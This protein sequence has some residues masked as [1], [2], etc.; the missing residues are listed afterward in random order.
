MLALAAVALLAGLPVTA[1][2]PYEQVIQLQ[3]GW[4][5]IYLHVRVEQNEIED[6]FSPANCGV[7]SVPLLSVWTF[8]ERWGTVGSIPD[9][10]QGLFTTTGWFG[11]FP[12]DRPESVLNNLFAVAPN[13]PYLVKIGGTQPITCTIPGR[14]ELRYLDWVPNSFNLV[15]LRVDPANPPTFE[16]YFSPSKAHAGQPIF[17]LDPS[18]T[19]QPVLPFVETARE[20]E[21]YWIYSAG[22]SKYQGPLEVEL[23]S[24]A[25]IEFEQSLT[26]ESLTFHNL[27]D[28]DAAVTLRR[29]PSSAPLPLKYRGFNAETSQSSWPE[30][31]DGFSVPV[32]AEDE[33]LLEIAPD[34]SMFA[35][36]AEQVLE[37]TSEFGARVLVPIAARTVGSSTPGTLG[38]RTTSGLSGS[39]S[40]IDFAQA[41][42]SGGTQAIATA[43]SQPLTGLW[44]GTANVTKVSEILCEVVPQDCAC[45]SPGSCSVNGNPCAVDGECSLVE[46]TC[47]AGACTASGDACAT[48]SDCPGVSQVCVEALIDPGDA[49]DCDPECSQG[50]I[51]SCNAR[52]CASATATDGVQP[53]GGSFPLRLLVHVDRQGNA[54]LLKEVIQLFKEPTYGPDPA[55]PGYQTIIDPGS[56]VLITDED[57][58]PEFGGVAMR[59]GKPVGL[60]ASTAAYDFSETTPGW[61]PETHSLPMT[62]SFGDNNFGVAVTIAMNKN[63]PTNPFRH[64]FHPDHNN[65]DNQFLPMDNVCSETEYACASDDDCNVPITLSPPNDGMC[66]PGG[67]PCMVGTNE[68]FCVAPD[69]MACENS[70]AD[71]TNNGDC[72]EQACQE[73]DAVCSSDVDCLELD[74]LAPIAVC[75]GDLDRSCN[76]SVDCG[77]DAPCVV[78]QVC[79][80][81]RSLSCLDDA[82]CVAI[83]PAGNANHRVCD[84]NVLRSC[85][86]DAD[87]TGVDDQAVA[88][89]DGLCVD[90]RDD[91][92]CVPVIDHGPCGDRYDDIA[93]ENPCVG[94]ANL[95][96]CEERAEAPAITRTISLTFLDQLDTFCTQGCDGPND[97][98]PPDPPGC[99]CE[100]PEWGSDEIGGTFRDVVSGLH[101]IEIE[102]EGEFTLRRVT[103]TPVLNR[104]P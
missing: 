99:D 51:C 7:P 90:A 47:A 13:R 22:P 70:F 92:P 75:A 95:G 49:F 97:P 5:S 80:L 85:E 32:D 59:D 18:G 41:G 50:E 14:P 4:N 38:R 10:V 79:E 65:L 63:F 102:A 98:N 42:L 36:A 82:G 60:R 54:R 28:V 67:D 48:D 17:R 71:C 31:P 3:P 19:W 8:D 37:V 74:I 66:I 44:I 40:G 84:G 43:P 24:G 39:R 96:T 46:D 12:E 103:D 16:S 78:Q 11:F 33:A 86:I 61:Q 77:S 83:P 87:C 57:L 45:R 101:R 9:P 30:L 26:Q 23:E 52:E 53:T 72:Q 89:D 73:N 25:V 35:G 55:T 69:T 34:R 104:E 2:S 20:G 29:L 15:G 21:A 1:Q 81:D 58:I 56:F 93:A 68:C 91:G 100:P 64:K 88:F 27:L 62:G 6:V 76:S 94:A